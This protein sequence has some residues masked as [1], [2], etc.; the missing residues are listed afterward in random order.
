MPWR[1]RNRCEGRKG[2]QP[3]VF[4]SQKRFLQ[5]ASH[6]S[7]A[8]ERHFLFISR[9]MYPSPSQR[10]SK[11]FLSDTGRETVS[12]SRMPDPIPAPLQKEKRKASRMHLARRVGSYGT[13]ILC[14]IPRSIRPR[15]PFVTVN[16]RSLYYFLRRP[17]VSNE[18][19][20]LVFIPGLGSSS[21]FYA[22]IIPYLVEAGFTCLSIDTHGK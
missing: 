19:L 9:D 6:T 2:E 10:N 16:D 18:T 3:Y 12:G 15:M 20:T 17:E 8:A 22:T 14:P 13:W 11:S 4:R 1:K 21:S 7:L 5:L